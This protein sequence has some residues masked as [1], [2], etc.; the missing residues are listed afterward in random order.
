VVDGKPDNRSRFTLNT[1]EVDIAMH[2]TD[3]EGSVGRALSDQ[4]EWAPKRRIGILRGRRIIEVV[5]RRLPQRSARPMPG[6]DLR[7]SKVAVVRRVD[8][9]ESTAQCETGSARAAAYQRRFGNTFDVSGDQA[10]GGEID[11]AVV[12]ATRA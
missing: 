10:I 7:R 6:L 5:E 11:D 3:R 9:G 4:R 8:A 1:V 12:G 2:N